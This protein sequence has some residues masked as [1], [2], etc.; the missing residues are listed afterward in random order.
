M[1]V[2]ILGTDY[3]IITIEPTES[4][5]RDGFTGFC[6]KFAHKIEIV[7]LKN[8][9]EWN[10]MHEEILQAATQETLRHE[11][12]HAFFYESGLKDSANEFC[13]AWCTN[14]EM[15]DWFAIQGTKIAKAWADAG[16][17]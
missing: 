14:E 11:I 12:I 6:D 16:C 7:N 13:G 8:H 5:I 15:I 9:P 1:I 2:N 3:E 10:D 17:L 4:L